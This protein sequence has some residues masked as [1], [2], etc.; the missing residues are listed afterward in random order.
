MPTEENKI[1]QGKIF[2]QTNENEEIKE[3]K[4]IDISVAKKAMKMMQ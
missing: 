4:V 2:V 1:E 3:L